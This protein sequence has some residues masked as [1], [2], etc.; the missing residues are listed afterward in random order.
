MTLPKHTRWS[1]CSQL[2]SICG[3][4]SLS[5][6]FDWKPLWQ[7]RLIRY[8]VHHICTLMKTNR[9]LKISLVI[10]EVSNK[11]VPLEKSAHDTL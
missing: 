9:L 11:T 6:L 3:R 2:A 10:S 7:S 4:A 1:F 8:Q 5:Y